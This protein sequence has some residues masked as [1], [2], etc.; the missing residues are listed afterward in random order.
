[1]QITNRD[2]ERISVEQAEFISGLLEAVGD[3]I[4]LDV[5]KYMS[6]SVQLVAP[7]TGTVQFEI[8]ND[9]TTWVTKTLVSQ[10]GAS[11]SNATAA[12]IWTGDIGARYFRVRASALTAGPIPVHIV[13]LTDSGV[14]PVS[15]QTVALAAQIKEDAAVTSGADML[16]VGGHRVPATPAAQTSAAADGGLFAITSEGK[17]VLAGQ[18][19]EELQFQ[20]YTNLT[21]TTDVAIK[22]AAAAGV[23]NYL[24]DITVDNTG[25]AAARVVV[26]DG[27]TVVWSATVPPSSTLTEQFKTPIRGTAA[28]ALNAALGA[29]GTVSVSVQGYLGV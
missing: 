3:V 6:V 7:F 19:A 20:S 2:T 15:T 21:A 9:G 24:T 17:V 22:A 4:D 8:S 13:A 27:S 14:N 1:M 16:L 10:S 23:R 29:T 25:A 18:G 12:G 5:L 11:A 26:K 28:T